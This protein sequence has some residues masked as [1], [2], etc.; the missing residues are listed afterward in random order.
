MDAWKDGAH[1]Y[2]GLLLSH[3]KEWN[4]P[5]I[6]TWTGLPKPARERQ[7]PHDAANM[8]DLQ[9]KWYKWTYVQN[10]VTDL[11]NKHMGAREER[12]GRKGALGLWIWRA[13]TA[14]FKLDNQQGP[15]GQQGKLLNILW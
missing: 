4:N 2:R 10:R 3:E 7:T 9:E 15:T 12:V 13:Q 1:T 11:E 6:A 14:T 5:F 8:Q